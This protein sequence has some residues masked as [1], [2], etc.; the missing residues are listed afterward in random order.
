MPVR[1]IGATIAAVSTAAPVEPAR[2]TLASRLFAPVDI[3]C[4]V[5]FRILFGAILMVEVWRYFHNQWINMEFIEPKFHFTYFGFSWVHPWP[6]IGMYVH[7]AAL[8]VLAFFILIGFAYRLSAALFFLGFTYMFLLEQAIYLNHFY[9]VGLVSFLMIFVPANQRLSVD[10]RL[11]PGIRSGFAPAWTLWILR[12]QMGIVYFFGGIAKLNPDWLNGWPLRLWTPQFTL[13]ILEPFRHDAWLALFLSYSGLF[14]DLFAVPLLLW[15][16]TRIYM[17]LV[18][19]AFHLTNSSLFEIGIFPWFATAMTALYFEPDWPRKALSIVRGLLRARPAAAPLPP[20]T[21]QTG[22]RQATVYALAIFFGIQLL[23]P[24]RHLLYPGNVSWTDE[25]HRFSWRMKLRQKKAKAVFLITDP[26]T[27][28]SW[29]AD[30][31]KYL[32]TWQYNEMVGRPD[33]VQQLAQHIGD[34]ETRPG[35]RRV[36]VHVQ[37]EVALNGRMPQPMIDP[38]VDLGAT[39]RSLLPASWITKLTATR[40]ARHTG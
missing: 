40:V 23:L 25:G 20:S 5:Y 28:R 26:E 4:L 8:G 29:T 10:A 16:R 33:M 7:F 17:F 18:L 38:S 12:A 11:R 6:G 39:K 14:I 36:E 30:L 2:T 35:H 9:F 15:R 19:A 21:A 3:A 37:T 22:S 1:R 24:I 31:K 34:V 32:P 27:G 13:P